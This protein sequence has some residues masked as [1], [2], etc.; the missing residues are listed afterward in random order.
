MDGEC[1]ASVGE[2]GSGPEQFNEP[3]G[4]SISPIT[5]HIHIADWYNHRIQVLTPDLTFS[6]SFGKKGSAEGQF[7][8]PCDITSDSKGLL[9]VADASNNRIQ[10]FTPEGQFVT[11][12]GTKGSGRGQLYSPVG[13][14]VDRSSDLLY[15][16]VYVVEVNINRISI[17]TSEG[18]FVNSYG[19]YGTS[20]GQFNVP[21]GIQYINGLLYIC[22]FNNDRLIIV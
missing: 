9:Y 22:D 14:T 13:I 7:Q 6:H 16:L 21:I 10:V 1:I 15:D 5:G 19:E 18:Q 8:Y 20:E 3:D 17:F 4:I 12:F 2:E 11:Q